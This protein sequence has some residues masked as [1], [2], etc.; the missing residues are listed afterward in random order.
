[1]KT[2]EENI[3]EFWT[4]NTYSLTLESGDSVKVI[5][6]DDFTRSMKRYSDQNSTPLKKRI[7]ELEESNKELVELLQWAYKVYV[8]R[9]VNHSP[10]NGKD[11]IESVL[12]NAGQ[13]VT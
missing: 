11:K 2:A 5:D 6:E 9:E 12:A 8:S 13:K 1:M 7:E 10:Y 3:L 4:A